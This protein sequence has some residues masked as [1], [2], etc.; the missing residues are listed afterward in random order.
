MIIEC[1]KVRRTF[2]FV[3]RR[4]ERT[5]EEGRVETVSAHVASTPLRRDD[6]ASVSHVVRYM[7]DVW[8][9]KAAAIKPHVLRRWVIC[10]RIVSG[11]VPAG[12]R[13]TYIPAQYLVPVHNVIWA[14]RQRRFRVYRF[15]CVCDNKLLFG[16]D[17][18]DWRSAL[19]MCIWQNILR[20]TY[21]YVTVLATEACVDSI[22][23]VCGTVYHRHRDRILV[24]NS[25][26]D[27][28]KL[29]CFGLIHKWRRRSGVWLHSDVRILV[30]LPTS[31]FV[32]SWRRH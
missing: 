7:T 21:V 16:R 18:S 12:K 13:H 22:A 28:R 5:S 30:E 31:E 4:D 3:A 29:F 20:S 14:G 25:L 23:H 27:Y 6:G 10:S 8:T 1:V 32:N 15:P 24:T 17:C 26:N 11:N 9:Y 19:A 2:C